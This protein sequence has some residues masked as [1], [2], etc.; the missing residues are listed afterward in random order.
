RIRNLL[1]AER[2]PRMNFSKFPR[3]LLASFF[4]IAQNGCHSDSGIVQDVL[5][6]D[7]QLRYI[8][9]TRHYFASPLEFHGSGRMTHQEWF[10]VSIPSPDPSNPLQPRH[11]FMRMAGE[12]YDHRFSFIRGSDLLI[13]HLGFGE[14]DERCSL[15]DP[16]TGKDV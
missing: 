14:E 13:H 5:W 7:G 12:S 15:F 9:N 2:I 8:T 4:V 3:L 10:L 1:H 11:E 6:E 16:K